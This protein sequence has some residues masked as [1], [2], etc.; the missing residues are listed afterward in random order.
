MRQKGMNGFYG[1]A[2]A[3]VVSVFVVVLLFIC[4]ASNTTASPV[5]SVMPSTFGSDNGSTRN[6]ATVSPPSSSSSSPSFFLFRMKRST[7]CCTAIFVIGALIFAFFLLKTKCAWWISS[8][9]VP[10]KGDDCCNRSSST[11]KLLRRG[12]WLESWNHD[13]DDNL[14]SDSFC[15]HSIVIT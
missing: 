15:H 12:H 14:N 1:N 3:L 2:V 4:L 6:L 5:D 11:T 10:L 13:V 7:W 9:H 8:S